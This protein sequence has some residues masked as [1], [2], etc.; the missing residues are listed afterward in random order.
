MQILYQANQYSWKRRLRNELTITQNLTN[1]LNKFLKKIAKFVP[2]VP[3]GCNVPTTEKA[4]KTEKFRNISASARTPTRK[5]G[6]GPKPEKPDP[7]LSSGRSG[8]GRASVSG[9]E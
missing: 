7:K 8:S 3:V 2:E 5:Y 9:P 6:S 4:R 1:V